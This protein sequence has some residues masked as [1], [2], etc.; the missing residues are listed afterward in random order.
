MARH[1]RESRPGVGARLKAAYAAWRRGPAGY[2]TG[3]A[4]TGGP[5]YA[6]R[7]GAKRGPSATQ[8]IESFKSIA[9][10][11]IEINELAL[12][13]LKLRLYA[14]SGPGVPRPRSLSGPMPVP[15]ATM[16]YLRSL[17]YVRRAVGN[18]VADVQE[19]TNHELLATLDNPCEDP[20]E[21]FA[22]FDRPSWVATLGRYADVLGSAHVKPEIAAGGSLP[23]LVNAGIVP[24]HLWVLQS[25]YVRA[26]RVQPSALIQKFG[27]F[28]EQYRPAELMLFRLRPSLRDPYGAA[29]GPTQ[30]AWQY[31]G[32]EDSSISMWDQ[33]LGT[34]ARP[35][36]ILSPGDPLSPLGDDERSRLDHEM[37]TWHAR[38]RAGRMAVFSVPMK[39]EPVHYQ[40][41]DMAELHVNQ[42][43]LERIANC[44]GVPMPLLSRDTN[45]ANMQAART[46]HALFGI[47]PRAQMIASGLT[48]LAQMYDPRLF[49]AFDC[50]IPEDEERRAKI[51][52]MKVARGLITGNEANADEPWTPKPY[53]D[54][55]W[56]PDN[57]LTPDMAAEQHE[58]GLKA[59]DAAARAKAAG[60]VAP[61]QAK[62][63]ERPSKSEKSE[64]QERSLL[65]RAGRLIRRLEKELA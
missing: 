39:L 21:A 2:G 37:N 51:V 52:D 11:C 24:T 64:K 46:L 49:F 10:A 33:L 38:G 56:W 22:Y 16:K 32:L 42:Y 53:L 40:G 20:D 7:F 35:N 62:P 65:R 57:L 6:D 58:Q 17:P 45:L 41:F 1:P 19:I 28:T 44:Y 23:D 50:S 4:F 30:A 43:Q 61:G 3:V 26:I 63:P 9:F 25:Q 18:A 59:A 47:E 8:L 60:P 5:M 15:P 29:Y 48:R 34:G 54:K 12:A 31:L 27:Y 55:P 13:Q 14:A 36:A